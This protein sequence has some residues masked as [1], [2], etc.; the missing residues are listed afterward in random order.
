MSFG[1]QVVE[2]PWSD[3]RSVA[4]HEKN[5]PVLSLTVKDERYP[6]SDRVL[7]WVG[8][9]KQELSRNQHRQLCGE[10]FRWLRDEI[11]SRR[12]AFGEEKALPRELDALRGGV[13]GNRSGDVLVDS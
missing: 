13:D 6:D 5:E 4:L 12:Q 11:E 7:K 10:A 9:Q 3:I 8:P 2:Y 1:R